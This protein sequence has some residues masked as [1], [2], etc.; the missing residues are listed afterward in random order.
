LSV[1]ATGA[2]RRYARALLDLALAQGAAEEVRGGLREAS[3]LLAGQAELRVAL[4]HPAVA[5][6][7]KQAIVDA[8]WKGRHALVRRLVVLLAEGERLELLP[9][10]ERLFSAL[11][12]DRRGVVEA[13]A[14]S[15]EPLDEARR[16]SLAAALRALSGREVELTTAVAPEILGGLVVRMDGRVYD[17]SV[18]GRLRALRERLAGEGRGSARQGA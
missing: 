3:R 5:A 2:A 1:R 16:R 4:E 13:E 15:V 10:V 7:R 14:L 18:R 6:A 12:N 17:G 8:V 9:E 11:W